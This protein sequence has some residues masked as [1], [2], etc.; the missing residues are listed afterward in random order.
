[1]GFLIVDDRAKLYLILV[2][3]EQL[4]FQVGIRKLKLGR[5]FGK[6]LLTRGV[7]M[8]SNIEIGS[9]TVVVPDLRVGGDVFD[10]LFFGFR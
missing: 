9:L 2:S 5:L 6:S 10:K 4:F 3:R 7:S 8:L 1:L